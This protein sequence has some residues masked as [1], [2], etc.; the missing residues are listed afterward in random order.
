M[1]INDMFQYQNV[2][3]PEDIRF[4]KDHGNFSE[5]IRLIDLRLSKDNIPNALR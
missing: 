3:L 1:N 4:H 5:A 2:G